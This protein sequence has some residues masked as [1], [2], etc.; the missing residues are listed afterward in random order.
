[1]FLSLITL[2][3]AGPAEGVAVLTFVVSTIVLLFSFRYF[4]D[5]GLIVY[6][7]VL[8]IVSNHA[9]LKVGSF[10]MFDA[11]IALGTTLFASL[12]VVIDILTEYYGKRIARQC[13][14][15][16]FFALIVWILG[17]GSIL[18]MPLVEHVDGQREIHE[19][20]SQIIFPM[21]ALF[22]ASVVAY[23]FSQLL[24]ITIFD[25]LK[26]Y[27][28]GRL[29]WLRAGLAMGV[30][31]FV[32]TVIFSVCAWRWFALSPVSWDTIWLTYIWGTVCFR[33]LLMIINIG[34]MYLARYLRTERV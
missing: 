7:V 17:M 10:V 12:A 33:W 6:S 14:F 24:D 8:L 23:I 27:T 22:L 16:G 5:K 32:D 30:S 2:L 11:P 13:V 19:A 18:A 28:E 3:Q 20:L 4:G 25:T 1:M 21:P 29:L 34:V 15:L 26:R 9:V 31:A